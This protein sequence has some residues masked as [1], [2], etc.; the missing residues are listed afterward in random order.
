MTIILISSEEIQHEFTQTLLWNINHPHMMISCTQGY[1][2]KACM[3]L[4]FEYLF[5]FPVIHYGTFAIFGNIRN[6]GGIRNEDIL[7]RCLLIGCSCDRCGCDSL[8]I[9]HFVVVQ[10]ILK[11][12]ISLS[13]ESHG[14]YIH[15]WNSTTTFV[16]H[17]F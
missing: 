4:N 1:A 13:G 17:V 12:D 2:H 10:L 9:F 6:F 16:S 5:S 14:C 11:C 3:K 8:W 7:E 15:I